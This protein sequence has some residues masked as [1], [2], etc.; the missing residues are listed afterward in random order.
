MGN[1]AGVRDRPGPTGAG[2]I[3]A[4][5]GTF[6]LQDYKPS[7]N[8][9]KLTYWI[10]APAACRL[11]IYRADSSWP[12]SGLPGGPAPAPMQS[13][14]IA[15]S[16]SETPVFIDSDLGGVFALRAILTDTSGAAQAGIQTRVGERRAAH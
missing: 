2:S 13:F 11:D 3:G 4:G 9:G 6:E 14:V 5:G 16:T 15:G 12:A 7:P 10:L 8:C 1:A